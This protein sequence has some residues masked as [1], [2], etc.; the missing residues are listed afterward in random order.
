MLFLILCLEAVRGALPSV[1]EFR[2][3]RGALPLR[4]LRK[5]AIL[6]LVERHPLLIL[7]LLFRALSLVTIKS[8][9]VS[10]LKNTSPQQYFATCIKAEIIENLGKRKN[11]LVNLTESTSS[12]N[13]LSTLEEHLSM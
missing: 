2:I 7:I 3:L 4:I 13:P 1:P 5:R 10:V 9:G 12:K 8:E 11:V 6:L